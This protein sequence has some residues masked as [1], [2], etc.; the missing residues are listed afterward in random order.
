M[1]DPYK[2]DK[3]IL[4][5]EDLTKEDLLHLEEA[6]RIIKACKCVATT[7]TVTPL[8]NKTKIS[9]IFEKLYIL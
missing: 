2:K 5:G 4:T 1:F 9:P 8:S 7:V 6:K 3:A